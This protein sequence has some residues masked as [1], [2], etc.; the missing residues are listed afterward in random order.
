[1]SPN[2]SADDT[3]S[4]NRRMRELRAAK[5]IRMMCIVCKDA[6]WIKPAGGDVA[7]CPGCGNPAGKA[8]P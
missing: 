6:G 1:M 2:Y 3:E 5:E 7:L 4:I 8:R